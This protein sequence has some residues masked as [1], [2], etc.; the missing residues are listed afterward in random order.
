MAPAG[1]KQNQRG[2]ERFTH[3]QGC[4]GQRPLFQPTG[5]Q[6]VCRDRERP[7]AFG[8]QSVRVG[9]EGSPSSKEA[10]G[11][12]QSRLPLFQAEQ[13]LKTKERSVEL[14]REL[15]SGRELDSPFQ[16]SAP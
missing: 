6:L 9:W 15:G 7:R 8:E 1:H 12:L 2:P 13:W 4:Y 10:R 16:P 3:L 11:A 5:S 14:S